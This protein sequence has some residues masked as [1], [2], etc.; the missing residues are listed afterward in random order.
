VNGEKGSFVSC[1]TADLALPVAKTGAPCAVD[2]GIACSFDDTVLLQCQG[3][4]WSELRHC[5]PSTCANT[6][7]ASGARQLV[8]ENGGFGLGDPCGF[9][10]GAVVCSADLGALLQC[11]NG[12]T[13]VEQACAT[14]TQCAQVGN[15]Y[16]C[17]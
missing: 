2:Q 9:P 14:G 10:A 12:I 1:G 11:T 17:Q 5:A 3:G 13:T 8:C 4:A 15:A 6:R 16:V 7:T